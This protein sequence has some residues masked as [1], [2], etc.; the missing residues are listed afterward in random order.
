MFFVLALLVFAG[1]VIFFYLQSLDSVETVLSGQAKNIGV[2]VAEQLTDKYKTLYRETQLL[3]RNRALRLLFDSEAAK[4]DVDVEMD[5]FLD[6]F[7]SNAS[8]EYFSIGYLAEDGTPIYSTAQGAVQVGGQIVGGQTGDTFDMLELARRVTPAS[9]GLNCVF[10]SESEEVGSVFLSRKIRM[11]KYQG[12]MLSVVGLD[13]LFDVS[14]PEHMSLLFSETETDR[15]LYHSSDMSAVDQPVAD[16][17][18]PLA[19]DFERTGTFAFDFHE[20]RFLAF[21]VNVEEPPWRVIAYM[22]GDT[23]L[24]RPQATGRLALAASM[25]F[26]V[27]CGAII[28]TLVRR[29]DQRTKDLEK[30]HS[31]VQEQNRQLGEA[32]KIVEAHNVLLEK[33]LDTARNMQMQL[34]PATSP[35]IDGFDIAGICRP[36]THVGG[37]FFQYFP[38]PDG[39]LVL[40]MADVSGHGMQ[41]AIP[42]VLFSGILHSQMESVTTL[43]ALFNRLNRSLCRT[44]NRRTF[45]CVTM[46]ELDINSRRLRVVNGGCPYPYHYAAATGKVEELCLDALPLGL[47]PE[48]EYGV[49]EV[50]L[51]PGDRLVF[52]SD[53]IIEASNGIEEMFGFERTGEAIGRAAGDRV[54]ATDLIERL[55]DE[56]DT[57]RGEEEQHDDQTI[58]A[59]V[60]KD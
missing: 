57:F 5:E 44:L 4:E 20:R 1:I 58:I 3:S 45:V 55:L 47:R 29:V 2:Q 43:Q 30:A 31:A 34:M 32:Q 56:V 23:Y 37:D 50:D 12:T 49:V 15:I 60:V 13:G 10:P 22:E 6:W 54:S 25:L 40:A 33:E 17:M 24:A 59:L 52:C 18:E 42:T 9:P 48:T 21:A 14:L 8:N 38:L 53:G 11:G 41:A 39:S 26:I 7:R 46:G 27:L 51:Q 35:Q 36:A 19:G 16:V 28:R